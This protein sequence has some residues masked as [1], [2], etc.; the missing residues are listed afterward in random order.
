MGDIA[1]E[2][3]ARTTPAPFRMRSFIVRSIML[4]VL[5]ALFSEP[6]AA[7]VFS[8]LRL[9][10]PDLLTLPG[11][12]LPPLFDVQPT[13]VVL[14]LGVLLIF[15]PVVESLIFPPVYWLARWLPA[16]KVVFVL[17]IGMLAFVAHGMRVGNLIQ[18]AGF[19]LMAAWYAHL[20]ERY[21]GQAITSPAKLPYYGVVLAHF[22]WNATTL[23]WPLA[24]GG[25]LSALHSLSPT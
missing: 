15:A 3:F 18:A 8:L 10:A 16:R 22:G 2:T 23:L 9:T 20:R 24:I 11:L 17:A 5:I 4:G 6:V 14:V 19:M 12:D 13:D 7:V 21:P 25:I 1:V